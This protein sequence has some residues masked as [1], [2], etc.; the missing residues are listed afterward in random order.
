MLYRGS[1]ISDARGS[2][3]GVTGSR[4]RSGLYFRARVKPTQ[5]PSSPRSRARAILGGQ[6]ATWYALTD[7][8]RAAWNGVADSWTAVN[9]LGETIK[10]SGFAWFCRS[11]AVASTLGLGTAPIVVPPPD[12]PSTTLHPPTALVLDVSAGTLV[13]T[14]DDT[15]PWAG[16]DDAR[17]GVFITQ[18]QNPG[19][20]SPTGGYTLWSSVAGNTATPVNALSI[21]VPPVGLV[22]GR[23]YF[24]RFVAEDE[25]GRVSADVIQR[26]TAVP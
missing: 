10:L 8:Q 26:V 2:F 12:I 9:K 17:L 4:N 11:N 1:I 16:N 23:Q 25:L 3:G 6:P 20:F 14:L 5:V 7:L 24:V 18:G 21:N 22:A 13:G 15:D 19:R